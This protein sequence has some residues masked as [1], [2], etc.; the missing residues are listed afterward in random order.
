MNNN[1]V[2]FLVNAIMETT[3]KHIYCDHMNT[4]FNINLVEYN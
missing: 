3:F 4:N 1:C 2:Q